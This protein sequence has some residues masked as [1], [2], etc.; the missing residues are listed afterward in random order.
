VIG[1]IAA[2]DF[3]GW[4]LFQYLFLQHI[5]SP[6]TATTKVIAAIT[7]LG[8]LAVPSIFALLAMRSK[9]P[10]TGPRNVGLRGFPIEANRANM[11]KNSHPEWGILLSRLGHYPH[12]PK[13]PKPHDFAVCFSSIKSR[14]ISIEN[15]LQSLNTDRRREPKQSQSQDRTTRGPRG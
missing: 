10:G 6:G 2:W 11:P 8:F 13:T 14:I 1:S 7:I 5:A 12:N 9:L 4:L 15:P 3:L